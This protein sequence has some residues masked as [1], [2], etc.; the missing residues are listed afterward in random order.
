MDFF[1]TF[2]VYIKKLARVRVNI[3]LGD[4]EK[5]FPKGGIKSIWMKDLFEVNS[6]TTDLENI[7]HT[8]AIIHKGVRA[9]GELEGWDLN[10]IDEAYSKSIASNGNFEWTSPLKLNKARTMKGGIRLEL[11]KAC[12]KVSAAIFDKKENFQ[13][14]TK[15]IDTSSH[16]IDWERPFSKPLWLD[17]EKFGFSL[18]NDQLLL[19]VN[20]LSQK[21]ETT[22]HEKNWTKEE[23]EGQLQRLTFREFANDKELKIWVNK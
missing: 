11:D 20:T 21:A 12:V 5:I 10:Q 4:E 16:F 18:I 19:F 2:G 7:N 6:E 8:L 1:K 22:I 23:L 15:L 17:N 13:F 14:T 9:I 3:H